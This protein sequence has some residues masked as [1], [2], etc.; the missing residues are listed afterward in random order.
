MYPPAFGAGG[1]PERHS[2]RGEGMGARVN[3][4]EDARH[5]YVLYICKYFVLVGL[6]RFQGGQCLALL[7]SRS[8]N[9]NK[10]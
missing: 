5:C 1:G 2:L 8:M 4:S 10:L 3:N 9:L 7:N 6:K